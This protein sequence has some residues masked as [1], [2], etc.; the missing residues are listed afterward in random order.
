MTEG[1]C[2]CVLQYLGIIKDFLV[3]VT[4]CVSGDK[5]KKKRFCNVYYSPWKWKPFTLHVALLGDFAMSSHLYSPEKVFLKSLCAAKDSVCTFLKM[6]QTRCWLTFN[7]QHMLMEVWINSEMPLF[8]YLKLTRT[9][10]NS[11]LWVQIGEGQQSKS[12]LLAQG[13]HHLSVDR[14]QKGISMFPCL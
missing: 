13:N 14:R 9:K 3:W 1:F 7:G 4:F 8:R 12:P 2:C 5:K 10:V 11:C 6:S